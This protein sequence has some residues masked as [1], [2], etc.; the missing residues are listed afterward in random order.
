MIRRHC[1]TNLHWVEP[2]ISLASFL[3]EFNEQRGIKAVEW[4][5]PTIPVGYGTKIKFWHDFYSI[6][7]GTPYASGEH[8]LPALLRA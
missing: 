8:R 3:F 4:E 6:Q 1:G 5:F 2:N 7:D